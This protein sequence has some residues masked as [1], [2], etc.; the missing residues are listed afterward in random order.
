MTAQTIEATGELSRA[1]RE[2]ARACRELGSAM[3]ADLL[4]HAAGEPAVFGTA[5]GDRAALSLAEAV[6]AGT[7]LRVLAGVHRLVLAGR[8]PE[9]V[10]HYPS[11]GGRYRG[12]VTWRA[13]RTVLTDRAAEL[14]EQLD[15]PPQTNEI[16]RSAALIGGLLHVAATTRL[17]IALHEIGASAGLNLRADHYRYEYG[18]G[19]TYGRSGSPVVIRDAWASGGPLP[20]LDAP[21]RIVARSGCDLDPVDATT[22]DGQLT[23]LSYVWP[24]Q[25]ERIDRLR[26]ACAL[27]AGVPVTVRRCRARDL[28]AGL[29]PQPG[30]ATVVWHSVM[31]QY[32]SVEQWEGVEEAIAAAAA[33]ATPQAPIAHLSFEPRRVGGR[34]TTGITLRQW[35]GGGARLLGEAPAHGTPVTWY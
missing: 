30:R 16:G 17:P 3:Y 19:R 34:V 5:L 24:D 11:A 20:P 33:A 12:E 8:A 32:L 26:G 14:T 7:A 15:R 2:Q 21:L 10:A 4:D 23:L 1:L 6:R 25:V 18:R 22:S 35:P 27:A 9:L 31:R 13:L 29:T 28:I